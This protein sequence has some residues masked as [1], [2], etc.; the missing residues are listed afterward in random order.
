MTDNEWKFVKATKNL[1]NEEKKM[2]PGVFVLFMFKAEV[3]N[4][5]FR[6]LDDTSI[7]VSYDIPL[8]FSKLMHRNAMTIYGIISDDKTTCNVT[9][10]EGNWLREYFDC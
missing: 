5:K 7:E 10:F 2:P 8:E 9:V 1:E 6:T 4:L 3:K